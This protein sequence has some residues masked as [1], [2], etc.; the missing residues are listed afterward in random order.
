MARLLRVL[1]NVSMS[2]WAQVAGFPFGDRVTVTTR[3]RSRTTST[4]GTAGARSFATSQRRHQRWKANANNQRLRRR[5]ALLPPSRLGRAS[6]LYKM[7]LEQAHALLA[8][9]ATNPRLGLIVPS[10]L[11]SDFGTGRSCAVCLSTAA[12]GKWLFGFENREGIFDIDS[13]FKFNPVIIAKG[14]RTQAIR[15]AFMRR[16]LAD[17]EKGEQFVTRYT[18]EQVVQFS[19]NSRAILEI[20]SQ[21]DLEVLTKIYANSVL[22]GDQS[23]RGWGIRYAQGEFNMTNDS[24]LFPPRPK[25]EEWGYRPDEYSRWIKGP[26][27]PIERLWAEL[28]VDPQRPVPI[29]PEC[30]RRI[31]DGIARGEVACTTPPSHQ[32]PTSS[33]PLRSAALQQAARSPAPTFPPA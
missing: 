21:R 20:Q 4:W 29:D 16:N 26:W 23:E 14:G 18:R 8:E 5:R 3:A 28:G 7:F 22:L 19:P 30:E 2:N 15:T 12:V 10:G 13:R 24:K 11:Y 27:K 31:R 17:W 6:T 9:N 1:L 33:P 32:P 25:W